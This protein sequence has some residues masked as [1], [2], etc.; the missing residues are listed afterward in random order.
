MRRTAALM[1]VGPAIGVSFVLVAMAAVPASAADHNDP[2][3]VNSIFSDIPASAADLYDLFGFPSD[4]RAGG[5]KVVLALTF[6]SVPQAGVLDPDLLYRVRVTAAPRLAPELKQE[7]SFAAFQ[8]WLAAVEKRYVRLEAPEVRVRPDGAGKV[9]VDFIGFASGRFGGTVDLNRVVEMASPDG[10]KIK[11]FVGGRDDAFFN[12]LPGFFRSINYAPQFYHVPLTAP[13]GLR[14]LP[15][16]K[17]LLEL[18]GNTLFNYDPANPQHGSGVKTDLP[19]GPYEW[20]GN[21]YKRDS[22]GNYRFVYSGKD[23]QAGRNVNAIVLE[24]PLA[25]LTKKPQTDRIVNAWGE[26]WVTK[27]SGKAPAIPEGGAARRPWWTLLLPGLLILLGIA[28]VLRNAPRT[29]W[30]RIGFASLA[31]GVVAAAG[32][33]VVFR[34]STMTGIDGELAR[35]KLVDTD[36][37]PFADAALSE[38]KDANQLGANNIRLG[39]GF[40]KRFGHLGWGFAPSISALG[41]QTCFDH[42]N[43]PVP[44]Y[45]TYKLATEAFPRVKKCFFQPLNMPDDSW[46]PKHLDIPLRRP[47]EVFIPNVCAIDM[48]TTG[49]WPFGRRLEDQVATRFLSVFLDMTAK[50]NGK[51]YNLETLADQSLWDAAPIEPKTPPNPLHN[52]KPFLASFPYLADPWPGTVGAGPAP[53]TSPYAYPGAGTAATAAPYPAPT[54]R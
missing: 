5:E 29:R 24:V 12:D 28:L 1:C 23:A 14:E 37:L 31:L 2:N 10:Q 50:R 15:I 16:P 39:L 41:L 20:K 18:E 54:P 27:A 47:F 11:L 4:D 35:Y 32:F 21:A 17:T 49:T 7:H 34:S 13:V 22:N 46:N 42:D 53:G 30:R 9:K 3:A 19:P 51:P 38:R 48:D 26:S 6:A 25:F 40:V 33:M 36:G 43:A 44:V 45:K 52:D 8:R